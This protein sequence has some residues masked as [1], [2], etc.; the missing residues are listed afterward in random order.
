MAKVVTFTVD[1]DLKASTSEF[2]A[3]AQKVKETGGNL[4]ELSKYLKEAEGN[5]DSSKKKTEDFSASL[6]K[7]GGSAKDYFASMVVGFTSVAGVASFFM[8]IMD[9]MKQKTLD[10]AAAANDFA[11]LMQRSLT[12]TQS[13]LDV[14]KNETTVRSLALGEGVGRDK[15]FAIL[16]GVQQNIGSL[17]M[18]RGRSLVRQA[19]GLTHVAADIDPQTLGQL[20]AS[21]ANTYPEASDAELKNIVYGYTSKG[22]DPATIMKILEQAQGAGDRPENVQA[23]LRAA[24]GASTPR[25]AA[26]LYGAGIDARS[27]IGGPRAGFMS[28]SGPTAADVAA[29]YGLSKSDSTQELFR[30]ML[31]A[32]D[33]EREMIFG[34]IVVKN[35]Q[36]FEAVARMDA[37]AAREFIFGGV[38][39][40]QEMQDA[41][42]KADPKLAEAWQ[43]EKNLAVIENDLL[44]D[45]GKAQ[46]DANAKKE[47]EA[48]LQGKG[49]FETKLLEFQR[50]VKK[51][52]TLHGQELRGRVLNDFLLNGTLPG[53]GP[54]S[55]QNSGNGTP[56]PDASG[57]TPPSVNPD[58]GMVAPV[59]PNMLGFDPSK[60]PGRKKLFSPLDIGPVDMTSPIP[61]ESAQSRAAAQERWMRDGMRG[62][63]RDGMTDA[64]GSS[65][66]VNSWFS[67]PQDPYKGGP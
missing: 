67:N 5:F 56:F 50:W 49:P 23:F 43:H 53:A 3:F 37:T 38:D 35:K 60:V 21:A 34:E 4:R 13:P 36:A 42:G 64:L 11:K 51:G 44:N 45:Q 33:T 25:K 28:K 65:N 17:S 63:I 41:A 29:K 16:R 58:S 52:E 62:A 6:V 59:P 18:D 46:L 8:G 32:S 57:L 7:A 15:G 14:S 54:L 10:N 61:G 27:K 24:A 55:G 66:Q 26:S 31:P 2:V 12:Y 47:F 48:I 40:A 39:R 22:H 30:K 1:A 19:A 20:M 9:A